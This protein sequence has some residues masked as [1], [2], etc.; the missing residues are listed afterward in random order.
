MPLP[1]AVLPVRMRR[2][3]VVAPEKRVRDALVELAEDGNVELSGE[4]PALVGPQVDALRRLERE[5][6]AEHGEPHISRSLPDLEAAERAGDWATLAGEAELARRAGTAIHHGPVAALVGW[7]SVAN[8]E[9]LGNRLA[10]VGASLVELESPRW[11]DPPT[12]LRPL[13]R[14]GAFRPLVDI[15]GSARYPDIDP[16]PFAAVTFVL[17]FGMMFGDVGHGLMLVL[18]ALVLRGSRRP[19]LARYRPLWPL[20]AAAGTAAA[21][22]G[23]LYGEAFGPTGLVPTLWMAPLDDPVRLL[24]VAIGLGAGL[25]SVSYVI[26]T[27][28]RLREDGVLVAILAPSGV[29]GFLLLLAG[30]VAL[31]GWY[32]NL[33]VIMDAGLAF[34]LLALAL[35]ALGFMRAAG[36][37]GVALAETIVEVFDATLRTAGNTVSFA[38]LAAFGLVHAA[39]GQAVVDGAGSLKGSPLGWVAAVLLFAIGNA[40]AFS[41]EALVAGVQALRLEYYELFS[42]V[43]AG[44]GRLFRPWRFPVIDDRFASSR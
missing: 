33:A 35:L 27:I 20:P 9:V 38:R 7:T 23:L 21:V 19:A 30:G 36:R 42:R 11:I 5:S 15:Y 17:M 2:I 28:N 25:L 14:G 26:G 4:L 12:L 31:L 41:L 24:V 18:L 6:R 37:G 8:I 3:A 34:G 13:R 39:I 16:T 1:D 40:I 29:A 43:F 32:R 10:S 44:E 22:F